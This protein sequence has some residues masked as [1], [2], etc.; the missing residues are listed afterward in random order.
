MLNES[1]CKDGNLLTGT[2][3]PGHWWLQV[4]GSP[5]LTLVRYKVFLS[6]HGLSVCK[7]FAT[8]LALRLS[9][10][11]TALKCS[12][13]EQVTPDS[14]TLLAYHVLIKERQ[15]WN[16]CRLRQTSPVVASHIC[17]FWK[18]DAAWDEEQIWSMLNSIIST[19]NYE[20]RGKLIVLDRAYRLL[21][22]NFVVLLYGGTLHL[23][24]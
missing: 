10:P 14:C 13:K 5:Q 19:L 23:L 12:C 22:W 2:D 9:Q 20:A 3:F 8:T 7:A 15:S 6:F 17:L 24:F 16:W 21:S 4:A 18:S 1:I 11:L